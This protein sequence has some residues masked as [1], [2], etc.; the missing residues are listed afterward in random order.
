MDTPFPY[1]TRNFG[2]RTDWKLFPGAAMFAS[3]SYFRSDLTDGTPATPERLRS[4]S[5]AT[6]LDFESENGHHWRARLFGSRDKLSRDTSVVN[7][8]RT[9]ETISGRQRV[10]VFDLGGSLTW[11]RSMTEKHT[12]TAGLD[13]RQTAGHLEEDVF[14][15]AGA[16]LGMK[17]MDAKQRSAG[18]FAEWRFKPEERWTLTAGVRGDQWKSFSAAA[19]STS[20][21]TTEFASKDAGALSPSLGAS[22]R[23]APD[24]NLRAAGYSGFRAPNMNELYRLSVSRGVV[25]QNNPDLNEERVMGG[26][27]GADWSPGSAGK[28]S[29]TGFYNHMKNLIQENLVTSTLRLKEN[30]DA[31]RSYGVELESI[32]RPIEHLELGLG[33]VRTYSEVTKFTLRPASEGKWLQYVPRDQAA[34][35]AG[36]RNPRHVNV[37]LRLRGV[38]VSY[39]DPTNDKYIASFMTTDITLS[40][41]FGAL[42]VFLSGSNVFD[43]EIVTLPTS[44][45]VR[46]AA[47]RQIWSGFRLVL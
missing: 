3:G 35:T 20:G 24:W 31:A 10:P 33:Y 29:V 28:V 2:F 14:N 32:C 5:G 26:E 38:G 27:A 21:A 6:G 39:A 16:S 37:L 45:P 15:N 11:W 17:T 44:N 36:W 4:F 8:A 13:M 47:P 34:F 1:A 42:E 18:F 30:L 12:L 41:A 46:L 43:R 40:K 25:F 22:F 7:A 9:A 23:I 19:V